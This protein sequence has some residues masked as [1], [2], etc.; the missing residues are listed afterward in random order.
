MGSS[1]TIIFIVQWMS[2]SILVEFEEV[3]AMSFGGGLKQLGSRFCSVDIGV[4]DEV[5]LFG[6]W[7]WLLWMYG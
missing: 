2:S 6:I 5:V 3:E 7:I 1:F 4:L